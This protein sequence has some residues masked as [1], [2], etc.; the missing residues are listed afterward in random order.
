M[1]RA[2]LLRRVLAMFVSCV[3]VCTIVAPALAYQGDD[4]EHFDATDTLD[5]NVE[6]NGEIQ[7]PGGG[8]DNNTTPPSQNNED[9]LGDLDPSTPDVPVEPDDSE[10]D[11]PVEPGDS[12]DDVPV[13]PDGSEDDD[14]PAEPDSGDGE[15]DSTP[16]VPEGPGVEW[17]WEVTP[18]DGKEEV[19][20]PDIPVAPDKETPVITEPD[21]NYA[22]VSL[23]FKN[24]V[25]GTT[26]LETFQFQL[27][28]IE[29]TSLGLSNFTPKEI[30]VTGSDTRTLEPIG[31]TTEGKWA[32]KLELLNRGLK[33]T[34]SHYDFRERIVEVLVTRVD[35]DLTPTVRLYLVDGE[36]RVA[37]DQLQFIHWYKAEQKWS[38]VAERWSKILYD[39]MST[40][41]R[42]G[43]MFLLHAPDDGAGSVEAARSII[44]Q[45]HPGGFIYFK[46]LFGSG[47]EGSTDVNSVASV[48]SKLAATQ[49]ASKIPLIMSIDEEG[50]RVV[51][52]GYYDQFMLEYFGVHHF[53]TGNPRGYFKSALA[54]QKEGLAAV[55]QDAIE[56]ANMLKDL[57]FNLNHAP[58]AD[59]PTS[60]NGY[61]YTNGRAY[62]TDPVEVGEYV[63]TVLQGMGSVGISGTMKHFPGYCDPTGDTH[64]GV[65]HN[66]VSM[67]HLYH[68]DLVPFYAGIH[69]GGD[70]L[71][72]THNI[73][74]CVDAMLPATVSPAV[75]TLLRERLGFD[76]LVV[77]DDLMMR[78]VIDAV[79]GK[80]VSLAALQA[81][82]DM[83]LIPITNSSAGISFD[84][85]FSA[86][87]SAYNTDSS[88]RS[89]VEQKVLRILKWKIDNG[90]IDT[91][92]LE[93]PMEA[94]A[95]NN[96]A[97]WI[98]ADGESWTYSTFL[99][100]FKKSVDQGGIVRLLTDVTVPE[101][102][103]LTDITAYAFYS[104]DRT[105]C[106]DLNTHDLVFQTAN[107]KFKNLNLDLFDSRGLPKITA[108][109]VPKREES[110]APYHLNNKTI[111]YY[112]DADGVPLEITVDYSGVG[113][114]DDD[115]YFS[116]SGSMV[117][118][119]P[120][121]NYV[122]LHA[123][124]V[125][126][127]GHRNDF[128]SIGRIAEGTPRDTIISSVLFTNVLE[129]SKHIYFNTGRDER[130]WTF[131]DC[132]FTGSLTFDVRPE[133]SENPVQVSNCTFIDCTSTGAEISYSKS[134]V[135]FS[136]CEFLYNRL[137]G[138]VIRRNLH[139]IAV[140]SCT[141]AFN[142][143]TG[144]ALYNN[145][146]EHN[147]KFISLVNCDIASNAKS[148]ISGDVRSD[149]FITD[150]VIRN[151]GIGDS[152]S[153]GA[154]ID[155]QAS[156]SDRM[157]GNVYFRGNNIVEGNRSI[158][159]GGG[160]WICNLL[161][162]VI[163]EGTLDVASNTA[164][165]Y[166]GGMYLFSTGLTNY[167]EIN[168]RNNST[169]VSGGGAYLGSDLYFYNYGT[170]N[171][172]GNIAADNSGGIRFEDANTRNEKSG[173]ITA[174]N[175]SVQKDGKLWG[176]AGGVYINSNGFIN[177]GSV[178]CTGNRAINGAGMYLRGAL[179]TST[180]SIIITDNEAGLTGT[181][182]W[183]GGVRL[184]GSSPV[185]FGG[186]LR[187]SNNKAFDGGGI[188]TEHYDLTLSG[189]YDISGNTASNYGGGV[190]SRAGVID[191]A[192][193][194]SVSSNTAKRYGGGIANV[195]TDVTLSGDLKVC[196]N[197]ASHG[198][199]IWT[200][201]G[202]FKTTGTWD[203]CHNVAATGNGGG[204]LFSRVED[205]ATT[206]TTIGGVGNVT[207]NVA[208]KANGGGLGI[209]ETEVNT[210]GILSVEHNEAAAGGG[211]YIS[212]GDRVALYSKVTLGNDTTIRYNKAKSG[213]G[214][215][216]QSGQ[217]T[218]DKVVRVVDNILVSDE[219]APVLGGLSI[220]RSLVMY[221]G[222]NLSKDS[223]IVIRNS[224][225]N[226]PV[227]PI[228]SYSE[229]YAFTPQELAG[230]F[231]VNSDLYNV[232]V[233]EDTRTVA[234]ASYIPVDVPVRVQ[235]DGVTVT[236][237]RFT[238]MYRG[239][240][241]TPYFM[242]ENGKLPEEL[243][244]YVDN[245][246][247]QGEYTFAAVSAAGVNGVRRFYDGDSRLQLP[248][249]VP[250]EELELLMLSHVPVEETQNPQA[251]LDHG[252]YY[253]VFVED[254]YGEQQ[255]DLESLQATYYIPQ[256]DSFDI[257]LPLREGGAGWSVLDSD[258]LDFDTKVIG[259]IQRLHFSKIE[260]PLVIS[261]GI[262]GAITFTMQQY[263]QARVFK[264]SEFNSGNTLQVLDTR[265]RK[266]PQNGAAYK[267]N[268]P[269]IYLGYSSDGSVAVSDDIRAVRKDVTYICYNQVKWIDLNT[270]DDDDLV[271]SEKGYRLDEVWV[272]KNPRGDSTSLMEDDWN[273]WRRSTLGSKF[274][275]MS[276]VSH[277]DKVTDT[278]VL[279]HSNDVVRLVYVLQGVSS[280]V[281]APVMFYDY[282]ISD[283]PHQSSY[284]GWT[285]NP[286]YPDRP[287]PQLLAEN[288]TAMVA[289][290]HGIN[291][292]EN[293]PLKANGKPVDAGLFGF[294]NKPAG[295]YVTANDISGSEWNQGNTANYGRACFG[296]LSDLNAIGGVS[297]NDLQSGHSRAYIP[298]LFFEDLYTGNTVKG[299]TRVADRS[300][301]FDRIGETYTLSAVYSEDRG[302]SVI[303]NLTKLPGL[304]KHPNIHTNLF[305]PLDNLYNDSELALHDSPLC[306][307]KAIE[308][309]DTINGSRKG[310]STV[311]DD[312]A[313][314]N[315][316]F[317]MDFAVEFS[318]PQDYIGDLEFCFF[319][320]DDM[321]VFLDDTL[322][323]D[324]GGVHP[325]FGEYAD[326]WDYIEEG[327]TTTHRLQVF[328]T[329]R[330]GS[331]STCWMQMTLPNAKFLKRSSGQSTGA[332][333][334]VKQVEGLEYTQDR[335]WKF[336]INLMSD[337]ES[338]VGSDVPYVLKDENGVARDRGSVRVT[339]RTVEGG[340]DKKYLTL[341][342]GW[343]ASFTQVPT[344]VEVWVNEE[345]IYDCDVNIELSGT[346][347]L[348][349]D[350]DSNPFDYGSD[351]RVFQV[352]QGQLAT[353][354]YTNI[355][356]PKPEMPDTGGKGIY[357]FYILGC[358]CIITAFTFNRK[359]HIIR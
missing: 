190:F 132:Y 199:G 225:Y 100:C 358:S 117:P 46:A 52:A 89:Q 267:D 332:F 241:G 1:K 209:Y 58:V 288:Y 93:D 177:N 104:T 148:G 158:R 146:G 268:P 213:A 181:N 182:S 304:P 66:T 168:L 87:R 151:N 167:G 54:L 34:R 271:N 238:K 80:S 137:D 235:V 4:W 142:G 203:V 134:A 234:L 222:D 323:I 205:Y 124:N 170:L 276:F 81:G 99:E 179:F 94:D 206:K 169:Q 36:E 290:R 292:P 67:E 237:Y 319:G 172:E 239:Q 5:E 95:G 76:G 8:D 16:D 223:S 207:S 274:D 279:L 297:S 303:E 357:W 254:V 253:S 157:T 145:T 7:F 355:Y 286:A 98:S 353:V 272:L 351:Y 183:G 141:S 294:G 335:E 312:G 121:F 120:L 229:M 283:G 59:V 13:E 40:D 216:Y 178:I 23:T 210:T 90:L 41:E 175:N 48:R 347:E 344:N 228:A 112:I 30:K 266:L 341:K 230:V 45:Y 51:R 187:V 154:G 56:K 211:I 301:V 284:P 270:D 233:L 133:N 245:L 73:I 164:I 108:V 189:H 352:K 86:V 128:F 144:I 65:V 115:G 64:Q 248:S 159:S 204:I 188:Y 60:K 173:I 260:R 215:A 14:V 129:P 50:G 61:M 331:G 11:V 195:H 57:G 256:G 166:G 342:D 345:D 147:G 24:V 184:E 77:T 68:E 325:A 243:Q 125:V 265:G 219:G 35:G 37:V 305:W 152:S 102:A 197:T 313:A 273:I 44:N 282:D 277:S 105:A 12:E 322:I 75:Y 226:Q 150:C 131:T 300:L 149:L 140:D 78:G 349:A 249:G 162:P 110:A 316:Y 291:S 350:L 96:E 43:Q 242:L 21:K 119:V 281:K 318:L 155:I 298:E 84:Q 2:K 295:G 74:D 208:L 63:K 32:F 287:R 339:S 214:I 53:E 346:Y 135:T 280:Q 296:I 321:W 348:V 126:I 236:P 160:I 329:E 17:G 259:K 10:D 186:Y 165:Q 47:T 202:S 308:C 246:T 232:T 330:G 240:D 217:L 106:L 261:S 116:S 293:Y 194:G 72:V 328:Y 200:G 193:D 262:G 285:Y 338:I 22:S 111:V 174:C 114:V 212:D 307:L 196:D 191:F 320:D 31:F 156:L 337:S 101:S 275:Q 252:A 9:I 82:A 314:H 107:V 97:M 311:S 192:G 26:P 20:A 55:L 180:G 127:N 153:R 185:K 340:R 250:V 264:K 38:P 69:A 28:Q 39:Q 326:L 15:W 255:E 201:S 263:S 139:N 62:S 3:I 218:V 306:G 109:Q 198:G 315:Y 359:R 92:T 224:K 356:G 336:D 310:Y 130:S 333:N 113:L 83:A 85:E 118:M 42:I 343:T 79:N 49:Q 70:A 161:H 247:P 327:D 227:I 334:V 171:V 163:V 309:M 258:D 103:K 220:A 221:I 143:Q 251:L 231:T 257:A 136:D 71:L 176:S 6:N 278:A 91:S 302:K 19:D 299:K 25:Y 324:I 29:G 33:E 88:F 18:G 289:Y 27:S 138:L 269:L 123:S 122:P 317:G 354:S 244:P